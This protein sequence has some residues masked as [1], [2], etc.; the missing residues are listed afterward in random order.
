MKDKETYIGTPYY[1]TKD[2][3]TVKSLSSLSV[4]FENENYYNDM[5]FKY[6]RTE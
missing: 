4:Y 2:N 3:I 5:V 1:T 6:I